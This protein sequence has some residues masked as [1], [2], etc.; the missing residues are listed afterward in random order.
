MAENRV[1]GRGGSL[2]WRLPADMRH[3]VALT[4][5]KP[6]I[7]GRRSFADIGHPL[8]KRHNI[9]LSRDRGFAAAGATVA[10][11]AD[12]ALAAAGGADEVMVIGGEQVYRLFL[13]RAERIY[14]TLVHAE[15]R[16]DAF[17]P[18]FEDGGWLLDAESFRAVDA[19]NPHA[20][21][22]RTYCRG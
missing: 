11:D 5:G 10:H 6:V 9:I 20:M 1:I 18:V 21:S 19:D 2:P 16:G 7:I 13:P 3:F 4:R 22:F 15:P 8:P 17:F 14:L 12:T